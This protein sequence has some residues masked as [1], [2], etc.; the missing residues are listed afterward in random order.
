MSQNRAAV[1][2]HAQLHSDSRRNRLGHCLYFKS[3]SKI[4]LA[5][6]FPAS[7]RLLDPGPPCAFARP[8]SGVVAARNLAFGNSI[9][10]RVGIKASWRLLNLTIKT[11]LHWASFRL[12]NFSARP[13]IA[14]IAMPGRIFGARFRFFRASRRARHTERVAD[15][16][17]AHCRG[18][19]GGRWRGSLR[20]CAAACG[21]GRRR[22][23]ASGFCL[24]DFAPKLFTEKMRGVGIRELLDFRGR[25]RFNRM[26]LMRPAQRRAPIARDGNDDAV[27]RP[28]LSA[29]LH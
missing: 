14:Q 20:L 28:I 18:T 8:A 11:A 22:S 12:I 25:A 6:T 26:G 27:E 10:G 19:S 7:E 9:P 24:L 5:C 15:R 1:H 29:T 13:L 4:A 21:F 2:Y 23:E 17:K 3:S 16:L